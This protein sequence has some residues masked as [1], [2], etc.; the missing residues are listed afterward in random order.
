MSERNISELKGLTMA[1]VERQGDEIHF[2]ATTGEKW[3]LHHDQDCCESVTIEDINGELSDL[4]GAPLLQAEEASTEPAPTNPKIEWSDS[5]FTWTFYKLA[6]IK[7]YVTVR[8]FGTS[9]G[10]YSERV[11]FSKWF[12]DYG[13]R[14]W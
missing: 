14:S 1:T 13:W 10:Y 8:F 6:T 12:D 3:K 2:T 5:S 7:G 4:A 9:N 11:S